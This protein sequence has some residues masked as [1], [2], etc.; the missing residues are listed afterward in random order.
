MRFLLGFLLLISCVENVDLSKMLVETK[1][2]RP[3]V[4]S[5]V[6]ASYLTDGDQVLLKAYFTRLVSLASEL[7]TNQ[8]SR[9]AFQSF[10]KKEGVGTLCQDFL[11]PNEEH[12]KLLA[13][14]TK[15]GFFICAEELRAYPDVIKLIQTNLSGEV[16]VAYQSTLSCPKF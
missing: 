3:Q 4:G 1:A 13:L 14:C 6:A 7:K 10:A 8:K 5:I 16:L 15:N 9:D 2:L 11:M 12:V